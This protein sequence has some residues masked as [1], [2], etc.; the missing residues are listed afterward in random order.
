M[1]EVGLSV[2]AYELDCDIIVREFK[3]QSRCYVCFWTNIL[4]KGMNHFISPSY[5]LNSDTIVLLQENEFGIK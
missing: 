2:E 4:E 5:E 3:L 1:N